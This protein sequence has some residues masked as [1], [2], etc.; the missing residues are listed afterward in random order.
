[1]IKWVWVVQAVR[2]WS[3]M[4]FMNGNSQQFDSK[5]NNVKGRIHNKLRPRPL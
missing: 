2:A 3:F 1:M 5:F 4:N